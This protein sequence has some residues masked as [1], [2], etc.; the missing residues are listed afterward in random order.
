MLFIFLSFTP[1]AKAVERCE[2]LAPDIRKAHYFYFGADFPYHYSIAQAEKESVCRHSILSSDGV[3]SEGFAQITW[4]VWKQ[5]LQKEGISE[6]KSIPNHAKA[7]AYINYYS[8]NQSYCKKLFEMY[9]IYNGGSLVSKELR[10]TNSCRWEDGYRVCKR[11]DVC[12]WQT[13]AGCK[14]WRNACDINYEYSYKIYTIA[15]KYGI[16]QS[17]KYLFW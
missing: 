12:V 4:S 3:G 8:Y 5:A 13:S 14:Q 6:I 9:Q 11:K 16:I 17:T 2:A 15:Q 7:Q 1:T 10:K